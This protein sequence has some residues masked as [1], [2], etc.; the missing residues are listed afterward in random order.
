MKKKIII[1]SIFLLCAT[2]VFSACALPKLNI[3]GEA[4]TYTVNFYSGETL[5]STQT[6]KKAKE[7]EIPQVDIIDGYYFEGWFNKVGGKLNESFGLSQTTNLYASVKPIEYKLSYILG[8]GENNEDNPSTYTVKDEILIKAPQKENS[9][10]LGWEYGAEI[11]PA[12]TIQEGSLGE[13]VLKAVWGEEGVYYLNVNNTLISSAT[14]IF[15]RP[16]VPEKTG[17]EIEKL[18]V[19]GEEISFPYTSAAQLTTVEIVWKPIEY[20]VSFIDGGDGVATPFT[21]ETETF[22]IPT[23]TK[24]GHEFVSFDD[25]VK[26]CDEYVVEKGTAK[27]IVLTVTWRK[28][29]YRLTFDHCN[30]GNV[31]NK[32]VYFGDPIEE[33]APKDRYGYEFLGWFTAASG[34]EA[35]NFADSTMPAKNLVIYAQW[36]GDVPWNLNYQAQDLDGGAIDLAHQ[37]LSCNFA[38]GSNL[39][40]GER[41]SLN[42]ENARGGHLFKY[43]TFDGEIYSYERILEFGMPSE[44][45]ELIAVYKPINDYIFN[46]ND[47]ENV[48]LNLN[49]ASLYDVLGNGIKDV[50]YAGGAI[51]DSYL[52]TLEVG[53]HLFA[54]KTSGGDDYFTVTVQDSLSSIAN[55]DLDY[56]F[57]Y[58]SV[59]L[60][61]KGEK[62]VDYE[63]SLNGGAFKAVESGEVIDGYD[64]GVDNT[65]VIRNKIDASDSKSFTKSGCSSDYLTKTFTYGGNVYDS[66]ID[67]YEEFEILMSYLVY[68]D[69]PLNKVDDTKANGYVASCYEKF[70]IEDSFLADYAANVFNYTNEFF[71]KNCVPYSPGFVSELTNNEGKVTVYY[72]V[73][74]INA[75]TSSQEKDGFT[76]VQGLLE[77]SARPTGFNN[78]YIDNLEKTQE[79]RTLYELEELPFGVKPVFTREDGDAYEV[80]QEARRILTEICDDTMNDFQ[81]AAKIYD[82]LG[83]NVTYDYLVAERYLGNDSAK[84]RCF[85]SYGALI[86]GIAVCDGFGSAMK[87]LCLIEG[88]PCVEICGT[89]GGVGHAWNKAYIGGRWYGFDSTWARPLNSAVITHE[90]AFMNEFELIKSGHLES[91]IVSE[92]YPVEHSVDILAQTG[93]DYFDLGEIIWGV[94]LEVDKPYELK[95]L[96]DLAKERS[97]SVVDF[98]YVGSES[99]EDFIASCRLGSVS[100]IKLDNGVVAVLF[101]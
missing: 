10:F 93:G 76:D 51:K 83:V 34:G 54:I 88:I 72:T 70:F 75:L 20:C 26:E 2:S 56:D 64:K 30:G 37:L 31:D 42:A 5:V 1:L 28:L 21:I 24:L 39:N 38:Q 92:K 52:N 86:D 17:Y 48:V 95:A 45:L 80:Y 79:I 6:V 19:N 27:N 101:E 36:N 84:F 82:Y 69:G 58:P 12:F 65:V 77:R 11:Y 3:F 62:D 99:V 35:F 47:P 68:V 46:I 97:A 9:V 61:F 22:K 59:T 18:K 43:W 14:G 63:C 98:R 73:H 53:V 8:G 44:D 81:K 7:L 71:A 33:I 89:G 66:V 74:N 94:S 85:T 23:P 40:V 57:S 25:G 87:L 41:V 60:N 67:D 4:K 29:A 55:I 78:F 96:I 100:Y 50:N 49:G 15:E 16:T 13:I 91:Q 90:Y 32:N